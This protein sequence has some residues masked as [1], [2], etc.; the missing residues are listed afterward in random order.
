[1]VPI[2]YYSL[3]G[4]MLS[5]FRSSRKIEADT[6]EEDMEDMAVDGERGNYW[7]MTFDGIE[8]KYE[9]TPE[10]TYAL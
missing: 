5:I 2:S 9:T 8:S 3:K 7:K 10:K 1:M 6:D 4:R